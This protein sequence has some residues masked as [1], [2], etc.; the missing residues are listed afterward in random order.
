M[1]SAFVKLSENLI[2]ARQT[3]VA[4]NAFP[5]EMP[6]TP[7]QAYHV[8]DL[9]LSGWGDELVAWKV[10]GL[11]P[12]LHEQFQAQRQSGPVFRR[13]L[14]FSTGRDHV[15]APVFA[16]GF[17]AIEAEFVVELA[18]LSSLPT[19]NLS[20][21]DAHKAVAKMF[22]GIEIASSPMKD[23]HSYGALSPICDFGNNVGVI[24]GPE[25]TNWQD[26]DLSSVD[27]SVKIGDDIVGSANAKPGLAGPLG[28]V[29]YLIEHLAKR[30][31]K[32]EAGDYI[33]TGA[34]TGAHQT[35]INIPSEVRFDGIGAISLELVDNKA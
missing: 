18:D 5:G 22:I 6:E 3:G 15:M 16:Q 26:L 4:P 29:T 7:E 24:I 9:C 21:E 17:A 31:H 30:G 23:T 28:A 8:Q 1:S 33:S 11:N 32:L 34:I 2:A 13:G 10:A 14:Q 35:S 25:I 20:I 12:D 27:V 19:S